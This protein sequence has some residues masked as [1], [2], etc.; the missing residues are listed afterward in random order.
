MNLAN[1]RALKA[2]LRAHPVTAAAA[3]RGGPSLP[4]VAVGIAPSP[5]LDGGYRIA[6]RLREESAAAFARADAIRAMAA[7][8][9]DIRF[10]G[11]I[12]VQP[13]TVAAASKRLR[14]GAS[15]GHHRI[16][17][18]TLGCFATA[19]DGSVGFISNNHVIAD[20]NRGVS[21]DGI[22]NPAP[23]DG[24]SN[25]TDIVATLLAPYPSLT[26]GRPVVDCAFGVLDPQSI[27]FDPTD[28]D[29]GGTL[30]STIVAAEDRLDVEKI[31]RTTGRTRGIITAFNL[32]DLIVDYDIGPVTFDDQIEVESVSGLPFSRGGDSGSLIF[33][34]SFDPVALLFAAS[35]TGGTFNNGLTYANPLETVI[36][37]LGVR[38]MP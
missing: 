2:E 37:M 38:L 29:G 31:G 13:A 36:S 11:P 28:L 24:G 20:T 21:G 3:T 26:P 34:R 16:T 33:D 8:E 1:A 4:P 17:A 10:T 9:V 19:S 7:G 27:D 18:G 15:V 23:A 25:P 12:R 14:I 5:S 32:D 6:V 35:E 30:G 22:L